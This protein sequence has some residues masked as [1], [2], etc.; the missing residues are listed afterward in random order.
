M[1]VL[2]D[3]LLKNV[4]VVLDGAWGTQLQ[5]RGLQPGECTD[6]WNLSHPD[7]VES[8][9][10]E[11]VE[12]GSR[13]ILSNTFGA[14]RL[15]LGGHEMSGQAAEINRK[16]AEISK[17]A[18]GTR[19]KVFASIGPTGKMIMTGQTTEEELESVFREQAQALAEGG[20]DGIAIETMSD[21]KEASIA[22]R[23]ARET[24]LPVVGCMVFDSGKNKDRTMMGT[25]PE[26][27]A[28]ILAEAGADA[29]GAN[30]GQGIAGF[31]PICQRLKAACGLPI[32]IKA[33]AGIPEV[34]GGKVVYHTTPE[35]F[36]SYVSPLLDAGAS[37]IG[38]CCGTNPHYIRALS[39]ALS[40]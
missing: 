2:L 22:V 24:G 21:P 34:I 12:A 37:F 32:W 36:V 20:A 7:E 16:G 9:A 40:R 8:V 30:C 35:E 6:G 11:Y 31:V 19:A 28:A 39:Q 33:N 3:E 5:A 15:T 18:A 29:I 10:R 4:P 27:A 13:I 23:A 38:G 25:T 26:Q 17:R 1:N 14:N